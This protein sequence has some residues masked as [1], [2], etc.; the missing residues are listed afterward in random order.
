MSE[1]I[2][3]IVRQFPGL[4]EAQK[5][6]VRR[7]AKRLGELSRAIQDADE[8]ERGAIVNESRVVKATLLS[9][10]EA[11]SATV[12]TAIANFIFSAIDG[13]VSRVLR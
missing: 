10:G 11:H 13:L 3:T 1:D 4:T 6:I 7:C 9:L 2:E 12:G 5:E 8:A